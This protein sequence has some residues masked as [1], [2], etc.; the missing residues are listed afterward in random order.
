M[1]N[2][3]ASPESSYRSS[4][5]PAPSHLRIVRPGDFDPRQDRIDRGCCPIHGI[6]MGQ[7]DSWYYPDDA[8]PYTIVGCPRRD[9]RVRASAQSIDGPWQRIADGDA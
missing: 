6:P 7:I 2:H 1:S 8:P 4:S 9:C 3:T 5:L